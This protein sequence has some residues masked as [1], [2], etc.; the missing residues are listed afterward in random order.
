MNTIFYSFTIGMLIAILLTFLFYFLK[1]EEKSQLQQI[2]STN[3]LLLITTCIFVFLQMQLSNTLNIKPIYF[4]YFYYIGIVFF[5]VALYFTV[6]I[7]IKTKIQ[8]RIKDL[9]LFIIPLICLIR[10]LD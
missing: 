7:F 1:K 4:S 6:K 2:F 10:A 3:I 9:F 8:F 5:P